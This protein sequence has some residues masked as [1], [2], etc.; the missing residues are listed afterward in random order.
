ML[1]ILMVVKLKN[2]NWG[3]ITDSRCKL[4]VK[5]HEPTF[6]PQVYQDTHYWP[7]G[8]RRHT[9]LR[10]AKETSSYEE[11]RRRQM[12]QETC[13]KLHFECCVSELS[14]F[15]FSELKL[16]QGGYNDITD[17]LIQSNSACLYI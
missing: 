16:K 11:D 12:E 15:L 4:Q 8:R 7:R 9:I 13:T 3:I 1:S 6:R 14:I 10:A 2:T 5:Y 17:K